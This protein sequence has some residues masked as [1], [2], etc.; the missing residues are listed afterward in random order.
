MSQTSK[1]QGRPE[2]WKYSGIFSVAMM[3]YLE[4]TLI[5][6]ENI[7]VIEVPIVRKMPNDCNPVRSK[8]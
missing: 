8:M 3:E 7:L 1:M 2:C 6:I 4:C 5:R